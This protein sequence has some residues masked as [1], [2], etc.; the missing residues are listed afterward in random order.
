MLKDFCSVP[1]AGAPSTNP[2]ELLGVTIKAE[3]DAI[4]FYK[5]L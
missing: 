1:N 3:E 4:H 5:E 2:T